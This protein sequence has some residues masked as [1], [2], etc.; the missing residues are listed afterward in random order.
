[1]SV[2]FVSLKKSLDNDRHI[3]GKPVEF[4]TNDNVVYV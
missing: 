2:E 1:M 4:K 3:Y